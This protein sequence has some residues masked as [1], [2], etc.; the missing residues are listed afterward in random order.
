MISSSSNSFSRISKR[1]G[2]LRR[3]SGLALVAGLTALSSHAQTQ[4]DLAAYSMAYPMLE[5]FEWFQDASHDEQDAIV[6]TYNWEGRR[7]YFTT[8][9][10][11]PMAG[12]RSFS[13]FFVC[14]IGDNH[15]EGADGISFYLSPTQEPYFDSGHLLAVH[16]D[17]YHNSEQGELTHN[18]IS[19]DTHL[20][21]GVS[22]TDQYV[23]LPFQLDSD[24]GMN[25]WYVWIDYNGATGILEVRISSDIMRPLEPVLAAS[26]PEV[27]EMSA[28]LYPG[29]HASTGLYASRQELRAF[30]FATS[31]LPL[32]PANETY[33]SPYT[34]IPAKIVAYNGPTTAEQGGQ[35]ELSID[36][37]EIIDPDNEPG[38]LW[39]EISSGES[40][41][42]DGQ[43]V[44]FD[45]GAYGPTVVTVRVYDGFSVG[46]PFDI[47]VNVVGEN[48]P[49]TF[50]PRTIRLTPGVPYLLKIQDVGIT[51]PD[52]SLDEYSVQAYW[53]NYYEYD[54]QTGTIVA[55]ENAPESFTVEADVWFH[56]NSPFY[57]N[58]KVPAVLDWYPPAIS[59]DIFYMQYGETLLLTTELLEVSDE[60]TDPSVYAVEVLPGDYY[61]I[62]SG[63]AVVPNIDFG[64][65]FVDIVLR[66]TD[67]GVEYPFQVRV[68][69][70]D[71]NT[72][73]VILEP[74]EPLYMYEDD[75]LYI[76]SDYVLVQD[77][78]YPHLHTII[79]HPG[80][81][82]FTENGVIYPDQDFAGV[83]TVPISVHDGELESEPYLYTV[84][85]YEVDDPPVINPKTIW[86]QPG[87]PR[88][89]T[90]E[91]LGFVDVDN[92]LPDYYLVVNVNLN[93]VLHD[94]VTF[95]LTPDAPS[96]FYIYVDIYSYD[97]SYFGFAEVQ[98]KVGFPPTIGVSSITIPPDYATYL[99]TE[100]FQVEDPDTSVW[101]YYVVPL[102]GEGYEVDYY[103]GVIPLPGYE[104]FT[105]NF[106]LV[107]WDTQ[108]FFDF[109]IPAV[110]RTPVPVLQLKD[111]SVAH[112]ARG[113]FTRL[114][115]DAVVAGDPANKFVVQF[116][117]DTYRQG[118]DLLLFL[119][120]GDMSVEAWFDEWEGAMYLYL[121]GET[122][123]AEAL[124]RIFYFNSGSDTTPTVRQLLVTPYVDAFSGEPSE[125]T[126]TIEPGAYYAL[127]FDGNT[128]ASSPD[129]RFDP[130]YG[131]TFEAWIRPGN[132][133]NAAG[134]IITVPTYLER[135][136]TVRLR[137]DGGLSVLLDDEELSASL[138][139]LLPEGEWN[140]I[141]VVLNRDSETLAIV[142]NGVLIHSALITYGPLLAWP[143]SSGDD[144][145]VY[146][147]THI[148]GRDGLGFVGEIDEIRIWSV[149][150]DVS[151]IAANFRSP[152]AP[153]DPD[154]SYMEAYFHLDEGEGLYCTSVVNPQWGV[155]GLGSD[156]TETPVQ[157]LAPQ[158]F[159]V[160]PVI[161]GPPVRTTTMDEDNSP[162]RYRPMSFSEGLSPIPAGPRSWSF[163]TNPTHGNAFV[164]LLQGEAVL[165]FEP[166]ENAN[167]L[168]S[169]GLILTAE[170]S[171]AGFVQVEITITP[172]NDAP[173]NIVEP[174]IS[175][176]IQGDLM[177]LTANPGVWEDSLDVSPGV[178]SYGYTWRIADN[179]LGANAVSLG[180]GETVAVQGRDIFRY[181]S[182][183][184]RAT[185]DG[186]GLPRNRF[187]ELSTPFVRL[188][189]PPSTYEEWALLM[190]PEANEEERLPDYDYD[191]DSLPNIFEKY[192]GLDPTVSDAGI[193]QVHP[194]I[195]DDQAV[196]AFYF[197][198]LRGEFVVPVVSHSNNMIH[199][200]DLDTI[201]VVES[202]EN[203]L[204]YR[205]T[206]PLV[207]QPHFFRLSF[208][209]M[210]ID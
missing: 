139:G 202:S 153:D 156:S 78:H 86:M 194:E 126:V 159:H 129:L 71:P 130:Y 7:G 91:D 55:H 101:N 103:D 88:S 136:F 188:Q 162:R 170:G 72:A 107:D 80:E 210:V 191:G 29:F 120:E 149:T 195:V 158:W 65:M 206:V 42:G 176:D 66:D 123:P 172:R 189:E 77:D 181:F 4:I 74:L 99:Y 15:G 201:E 135:Y 179:D 81:N 203:T 5:P 154:I 75:S 87:V 183:T 8:V 207:N 180:E 62:D 187:S 121:Y 3:A 90:F 16:L 76:S 6:L 127:T 37:F 209:P 2:A 141:A 132:Y 47:E 70:G 46:P 178:I 43:V 122:A 190:L 142:R 148:G 51:D 144:E 34:S 45:G 89:I 163:V 196:F 9:N 23:D 40:Y 115:E 25:T 124:A 58:V 33:G 57:R 205:A 204:R 38:D 108:D 32:D 52:S 157:E 116:D 96:S 169:I 10:P 155:L 109:S 160:A 200:Q 26:V 168:E 79:V 22:G 177:L 145:Y 140:H 98:A 18:S 82:Y 68:G 112:R 197:T 166:F 83:L 192:M 117:P 167:G 21:S 151:T 24:D 17:T 137:D 182:L 100:M 138:P 150:R 63:G 64:V 13:A 175:S 11:L 173:I 95:E 53:G 12:D 69:V 152:I 106:R 35:L 49:P 193:F 161:A 105:L 131:A 20:Q 208:N 198:V 133:P 128:V 84:V 125:F 41:G 50:N 28:T 1:L 102:P 118:E 104:S 14:A 97:Q 61:L 48:Q 59:K 27:S 54:W 199:W 30:L 171:A 111:H 114:F 56:G 85:V 113:P 31:Y 110:V 60:D 73:P 36:D 143:D 19:V 147:V 119:R 93:L 174:S 39:L 185:D 134:D 94:D 92:D 44:Y 186:E 146:P 67:T 165:Y 164:E 184:V